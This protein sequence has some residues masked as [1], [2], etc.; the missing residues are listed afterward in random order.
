MEIFG[1]FIPSVGAAESDA[2]LYNIGSISFNNIKDEEG[3]ELR[4]QFAALLRFEQRGL[5]LIDEISECGIDGL[6]LAR[7]AFPTHAAFLYRA[8]V[9]GKRGYFDLND[10]SASAVLDQMTQDQQKMVQ[11]YYAELVLLNANLKIQWTFCLQLIEA[12]KAFDV[13]SPLD[14][15]VPKDVNREFIEQRLSHNHESAA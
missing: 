2:S 9:N 1:D 12:R 13:N 5:Q 15:I 6:S 10:D 4:I 3:I 8:T 14:S 11:G 7:R